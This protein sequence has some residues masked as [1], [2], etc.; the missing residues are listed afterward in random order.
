MGF[1]RFPLELHQQVL[2]FL[3]PVD[4]LALRKV[5]QTFLTST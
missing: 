5:V 3:D 2:T 4:I 1:D